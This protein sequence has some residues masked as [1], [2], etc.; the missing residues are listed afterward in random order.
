MGRGSAFDGR[1]AD[2]RLPPFASLF[3]VIGQRLYCLGTVFC[4]PVQKIFTLI[5]ET[6]KLE[7][8]QRRGIAHHIADQPVT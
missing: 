1:D 2:E 8:V 7:Y 5:L 6:K 4:Q 3:G